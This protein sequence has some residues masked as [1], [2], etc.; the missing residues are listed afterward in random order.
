MRSTSR[1]TEEAFWSV[2]CTKQAEGK[3]TPPPSIAMASSRIR[4]APQG[5]AGPG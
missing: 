3:A 1:A 4:C 5:Y 2:K